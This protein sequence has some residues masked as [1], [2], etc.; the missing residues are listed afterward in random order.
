ME[1]RRRYGSNLPPRKD[2]RVEKPRDADDDYFSITSDSPGPNLDGTF[3]E[4]SDSLEEDSE[5]D[6]EEGEVEESTTSI[7]TDRSGVDHAKPTVTP[8]TQV[9]PHAFNA[10]TLLRRPSLITNHGSNELCA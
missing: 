10:I 5:N 1:R 2:N 7:Q 8:Q 6:L 4:D 9:F 3:D